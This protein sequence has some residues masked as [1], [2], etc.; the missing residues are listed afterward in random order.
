MNLDFLS[1]EKEILF[2]WF[3]GL[4]TRSIQKLEGNPLGNGK[5]DYY[6]QEFFKQYCIHFLSIRT[7]APGL[8]LIY[9]SRENEISALAPVSV[10]LRAAL[11]NFSMFHYIYMDSVDS[12]ETHFRFWS[13]FREGLMYRQRLKIKHSPEKLKEEKQEID[14]ILNEFQQHRSFQLLTKKQK[15]KYRNEG[16]WCFLS[17][18][19]LL[20]RAG[21]SKP[22]SNNCY[23]F[24][25]SYTHPTSSAQIQTAQADFETS[26]EILRTMLKP[27][28]ICTALY[29]QDYSL[30]FKDVDNLLIEKDREFVG[31]WCE[32]GAELMKEPT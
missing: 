28:F 29:L 23:N 5:L 4:V 32:F 9:K 20:D 12:Q 21:F 13:W 11:E 26:N 3:E 22:L 14:R 27:L 30:M 6:K 10:L 7:L 31:T 16:T 8:K 18:R 15:V 19:E 25:S 1:L 2:S 24:F 17:M